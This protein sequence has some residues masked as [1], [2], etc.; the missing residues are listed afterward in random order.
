MT[1]RFSIRLAKP[2]DAP[3]LPEVERSAGKAFRSVAGLE[4][5][6][7]SA[8]LSEDEHLYWMKKASLWIAENQK[9]KLCGFLVAEPFKTELRILEL[10][11]RFSEQRAGIG[12]Q[13]MTTAKEYALKNGL[14]S[15]T[16]T[17]FRNLKFNEKFYAGL[18]F[19]TLDPDALPEHLQATLDQ[20]AIEGLPRERR[21]AMRKVL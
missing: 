17:T 18:G 10:S 3:H 14:D 16:L 21:C 11:V 5:V 4:W 15:L 12:R 6:A 13:L 8:V 19:Q 1:G 2:S 20:E 7:D 9:Q